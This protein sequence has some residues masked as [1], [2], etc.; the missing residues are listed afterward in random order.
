MEM[1]DPKI[2]R[3]MLIYL[4]KARGYAYADPEQ[5]REFRESLTM[6]EKALMIGSEDEEVESWKQ[7]TMS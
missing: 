2:I 6:E 7:H 5:E 4:V 3:T 1:R